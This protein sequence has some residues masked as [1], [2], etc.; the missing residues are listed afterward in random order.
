MVK[1]LLYPA[2]GTTVEYD[3]DNYGVT[4]GV[5]RFR[6]K[7]GSGEEDITTTV[8]FLVRQPVKGKVVVTSNRR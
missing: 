6:I 3:V 2:N 8:P 1:I 7:G 4:D 5:L